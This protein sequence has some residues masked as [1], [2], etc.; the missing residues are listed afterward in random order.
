MNTPLLVDGMGMVTPVGHDARD[1]ADS[2]FSGLRRF[3]KAHVIGLDGHP[4]VM[5]PVM[6]V[7]KQLQGVNRLL[8]L[9]RPA[10]EECLSSSSVTP[11]ERLGV[12][13]C[14]S[15]Q[16]P[17]DAL[18]PELSHLVH[19][20]E[21]LKGRELPGL[22]AA[23]LQPH[24]WE[25]RQLLEEVVL[26]LSSLHPPRIQDS[27]AIHV[28]GSQAAGLVGLRHAMRMLQ[29]R[30]V[31]VCLLVGVDSFCEAPLLGF[32]DARR[33]I[34]SLYAPSGFIPGE[35][36][37]VIGLRWWWGRPRK[38]QAD[39]VHVLD[40]AHAEE[41]PAPEGGQERMAE[42]M[43]KALQEVLARASTNTASPDYA[44]VN[45]NGE[46]ERAREWFLAST[47][48][49]GQRG[50]QP[51]LCHP[52]DSLGDVG[53]AS[54]P[55]FLG[56]AEKRLAIERPGGCALVACSHSGPGTRAAAMLRH[57]PA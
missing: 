15:A 51:E 48:A 32:W 54:G 45:L 34:K 23:L 37:G 39:S 20:V 56:L 6:P 4:L 26:F 9:V 44:Y 17:L 31:D 43:T 3:R 40:W 16:A 7:S 27:C 5:S 55:L 46:R 28:G 13:L 14:T 50:L 41:G 2:V 19:Q 1:T 42:A 47:R 21:K 29:N 30:S 11:R 24:G 25:P 10:L 53:A 18:P 12:V 8:P 49:L 35:A 52:A 33:Q 57:I 22:R 38:A 36:A